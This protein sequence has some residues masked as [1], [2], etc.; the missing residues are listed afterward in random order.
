M[1]S[2]NGKRTKGHETFVSKDELWILF[3]EAHSVYHREVL[4]SNKLYARFVRDFI[5]HSVPIDSSDIKD[6][7]I[8][9]QNLSAVYELL[10]ERLDLVHLYL[11]KEEFTKE[12]YKNMMLAFNT[13]MPKEYGRPMPLGSFSDEQICMITAFVNEKKLF[14]Q[15]V[16]PAQMINFFNADLK[17]PLQPC[18][19]GE[20]A[21]FL[22]SLREEQY[23]VYEWQKVIADNQLLLSSK[24]G[25]PS[26]RDQIK[27]ALSD[28]RQTHKFPYPP[29]VSFVKEMKEKTEKEE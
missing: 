1:F 6:W 29:F 20:I 12:C 9:S 25:K 11:D 21:M 17:N 5:S 27:N 18:H 2:V 3:R 10:T 15:S 7:R 28:F 16:K 13:T 22:S 26:T 4:N 23:L 24:T 14:K 19:N 8:H